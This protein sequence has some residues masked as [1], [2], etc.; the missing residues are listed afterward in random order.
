MYESFIEFKLIFLLIYCEI[1]EHI[2]IL[3]RSSETKHFKFVF[4]FN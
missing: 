3:C 1:N 2:M 4:T